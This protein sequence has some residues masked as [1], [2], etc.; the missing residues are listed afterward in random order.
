M[1][2]DRFGKGFANF[3]EGRWIVRRWVDGKEERYQ[4]VGAFVPSEPFLAVY[5]EEDDDTLETEPVYA[6]VVRVRY[7]GA[8]HLV[9][10]L[11]LVYTDGFL[12][13]ATEISNFVGVVPARDFAR[14]YDFF[15]KMGR[16]KTKMLNEL[17]DR[18]RVRSSKGESGSE[19]GGNR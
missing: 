15:I 14:M 1:D 10:Y 9:E 7:T 19:K 16:E 12:E 3:I 17:I 11:P 4:Y 8:L 18:M 13:D 5:Y 6:F 2:L